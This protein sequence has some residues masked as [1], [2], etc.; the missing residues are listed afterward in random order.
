LGH[1]GFVIRLRLKNGSLVPSPD[2]KD[3]TLE[4]HAHAGAIDQMG[5]ELSG[6]I[7]AFAEADPEAKYQ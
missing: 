4:A 6:I 3:T 2:N 1:S 5:N 7:R